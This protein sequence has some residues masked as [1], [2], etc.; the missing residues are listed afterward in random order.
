MVSREDVAAVIVQCMKD[1]G[2]IGLAFDVV[3]GDTP[4][5]EAISQVS[6]QKIDTFEGFV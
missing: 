4:I 6:K 1:T 3:G 5:S 2:T